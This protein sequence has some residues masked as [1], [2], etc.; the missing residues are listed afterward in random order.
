MNS[1]STAEKPETRTA[2]YDPTYDRADPTTGRTL[3]RQLDARGQAIVT[4]P[5]PPPVAQGDGGPPGSPAGSG[6]SLSSSTG[7]T[8]QQIATTLTGASTLVR[9]GVDGGPPPPGHLA[10]SRPMFNA[11]VQ[12]H[13]EGGK[14]TPGEAMIAGMTGK[15][16]A[17]LSQGRVDQANRM[18]YGILQAANLEAAA[19]GA[20][21]RDALARGD[22]QG[23]RQ[24]AV[25]GLN[26]IADGVSHRLSADG[27]MIE[28]YDP[29]T[30]LVTG[31]TPA[32][33][34]IVLATL[35]G[36]DNGTLFWKT[37][38]ASAQMLQKPDRNA[39]GRQL[40]NDL[41]RRQIAM[42]DYRLAHPPQPRGGGGGATTS[43]GMSKFQADL[44]RTRGERPPQQSV[45]AG[46]QQ[47]AD[48]SDLAFINYEVRDPEPEPE[49]AEAPS[50]R[51]S[52]LD[53]EDYRNG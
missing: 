48:N 12:A 50:R 53:E 40:T 23:A 26:Y 11:F 32:D 43:P 39:E 7:Y 20:A 38:Q 31:Q 17:M 15:Y 2:A 6:S 18:A 28:S 33:G 24:A 41:R 14:L 34:R 46:A 29:R 1:P 49:V 5:P 3:P 36:L 51:G 45:A 47:S 25:D 16:M 21:G 9:P 42:A 8:N 30:G 4:G 52:D 19:H 22:I 10:A 37:L 13:N 35:L 27:S 44:A